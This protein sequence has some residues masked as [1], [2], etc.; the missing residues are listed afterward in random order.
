VNETHVNGGAIAARFRAVDQDSALHWFSSRNRF[1]EYGFFRHFLGSPA[2]RSALPQLRIPDPLGMVKLKE[3][4]SGTLTIDGEFAATIVHGGAYEKYRGTAAQ[5]KLIAAACVTELVDERNEDFLVYR[6]HAA[7]AP[8]FF[9][10]AWDATWM[11]IDNRDAR[12]TLLCVT[13][14]D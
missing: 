5:A 4:W 6:S 14:T 11:I 12:I 2:V 3:S 9:D 10:I 13:D 1:D 8:W 7:W